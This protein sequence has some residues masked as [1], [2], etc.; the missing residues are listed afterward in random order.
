[1][2]L[3]TSADSNLNPDTKF[4]SRLLGK[5]LHRLKNK[6]N[7]DKLDYNTLLNKIQHTNKGNLNP[8]IVNE[9][10]TFRTEK[11]HREQNVA[12]KTLDMKEFHFLKETIA[13]KA[14]ISPVDKERSNLAVL[15]PRGWQNRYMNFVSRANFRYDVPEDLEEKMNTFTDEL[16]YTGLPVPKSAH[17]WGDLDLWPKRSNLWMKERP[18]GSYYKHK[19]KHILSLTCRSIFAMLEMLDLVT[20]AVDSV[21]KVSRKVDKFNHRVREQVLSGKEWVSVDAKTDIDG[22]FNNVDHGLVKDAH[23]WLEAKWCLRFRCRKYVQTPRLRQTTRCPRTTFSR[24]FGHKIR[25]YYSCKN[26]KP[27]ATN[28]A[29]VGKSWYILHYQDVSKNVK[30]DIDYG[31]LFVG[32]WLVAPGVGITQGSGTS[33]G[34]AILCLTFLEYKGM[35]LLIDSSKWTSRLI[36]RLVDDIWLKALKFFVVKS[37]VGTKHVSTEARAKQELNGLLMDIKLIYI[38]AGLGLK[39]EDPSTVIGL[40][41]THLNNG[42]VAMQTLYTEQPEVKFQHFASAKP[43]RDK[44]K[45]PFGRICAVLDNC[46]N[47][48]PVS[49]LAKM[50]MHFVYVGYTMQTLQMVARRFSIKHPYLADDLRNA[51]GKIPATVQIADRYQWCCFCRTNGLFQ[52]CSGCGYVGH[53]KCW[54]KNCCGWQR[55]G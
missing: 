32:A 5:E 53:R 52:I 22:F 46:M 29:S 37:S 17:Q 50:F 33:P 51:L 9:T 39:T 36:F 1:M 2:P 20:I 31:Y 47:Q 15:C 23:Q 35:E 11:L 34:V 48:S 38:N 27:M 6:L 14:V 24:S 26:L 7:L 42:E 8:R 10:R 18:L 28:R 12:H 25:Q 49:S 30:H 45:L 4:A 3:T 44:F 19:H 16:R 55:S 41:V 40:Q 43:R 21:A 13:D 54:S